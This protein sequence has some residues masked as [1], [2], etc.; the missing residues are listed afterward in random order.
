M[1]LLLILLIAVAAFAAVQSYRHQCKFAADAAWVDC[2]LGRGAE[3]TTTSGES[4]APS[5]AP[6][7]APSPSPSPSPSPQP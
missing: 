1:R 6:E 7:T 3:S 4:P 2:V 5:P